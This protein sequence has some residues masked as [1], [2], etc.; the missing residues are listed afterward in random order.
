[1]EKNSVI[2]LRIN[3][4]LKDRFQNIVSKDGFTMSEVIEGCMNDIVTR[5]YIPINVRSKLKPRFENVLTIPFI[6]QCLEETFSNSKDK[7]VKTA[8][9]FGSYAKGVAGPDSDVD[10]FIEADDSF[11]LFNLTELQNDLEKRLGKKV[12]LITES[13]DS[14][15]MSHI[16][17]EKIQLYEREK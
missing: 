13:D 14:H 6:K 7:K 11:S 3:N 8:S 1:M 5:G 4:N 12:D 10:I 9:I 2:N 16:Q 17:K 15:F